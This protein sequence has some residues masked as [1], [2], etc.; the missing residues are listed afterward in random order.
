MPRGFKDG[1][2]RETQPGRWVVRRRYT[3]LKGEQ[4]EKKRIAFSA[5]EAV[6]LKRKIDRDIE[7][8]LAGAAPTVARARSFSDLVTFC[9][10]REVAPAEYSGETK[11]AGMRSWKSAESYL[12]TL[13]A[14]F[15]PMSIAAITYD[16]LL[17]YKRERLKGKTERGGR[18]SIASVNRELTLLRK[19]FFVALRERWITE[20]PFHRGA[21]LIQNADEVERMRILTF[22]EEEKLLTVCTGMRAHLRL[23]L[24]FA[25]E[26]GM[27]QNE[28]LT[29]TLSDIDLED[30]IIEL[31][32]FN[33]KTAR[34]R[35]IPIFGRLAR[36]LQIELGGLARRNAKPEDLLFGTGK[37]RQ[38]FT[39]ACEL[40][41]I[42]GLRWHDLRH[43]A[44]TRM[45][46]TY[47]LQSAEVMKISGH[48]NLKTFLRYVNIDRE[49]ARSI[50]ARVDA[51]RAVPQP[52]PSIIPAAEAPEIFDMG[53]IGEAG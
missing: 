45:L 46:H 28:Q 50:A 24:I 29:L 38:A 34:R 22:D 41:G 14:F 20:H 27:R 7:S 2:V 40:A 43:T 26:T 48:T 19:L 15:G 35:V 49:V 23:Q 18:R 12:K 30:G 10:Q 5:T 53:D 9:R 6:R 39:R 3:N 1:S 52:V 42:E 44:I 37:P 4:K 47:G 33:S 13:G 17:D 21:P 25:L 31:R 36:E 32:A 8:E 51:A 11:I 16:D